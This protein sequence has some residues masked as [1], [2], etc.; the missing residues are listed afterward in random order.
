[1]NDRQKKLE[2][3]QEKLSRYDE[4]F[5]EERLQMDERE[6]IYRGRNR[7]DELV[8]GDVI[9][10]TPHVRNIAAEL[11]EAQVDPDIPQPKVTALRRQDE[12]L[13]VLI[14]DMLR[15]KLDSLPME[16]L[17]D[18][19]ERTVPIQGGGLFVLE[20]DSAGK[21]HD[22]TGR[23][24]V[25]VVHPKQLSP[26]PGV[27]GDMEEME[28]F[29]LKLPQTK[30][31][32]LRRYGVDVSEGTEEEPEIRGSG[33]VSPSDELVTQYVAYYRNED[34][35]IGLFSWVNDTVLEDLED[36]QSRVLCRC[37]SCG[38]VEPAGRLLPEAEEDDEDE[39]SEGAVCPV[40]GGT[41]RRRT[42]EFEELWLPVTRSDGTVIPGAD[43]VTGEPNLIPYYKPDI[44]PV[45]LQKSVSVY[46]RLLGESDV[47]KVRDQQ[48]TIN[49]LEKS[50][51]DQLLAAGTYISLPPD[52][53]IRMDTGVAKVI[54][55][56]NVTDKNYLG[57]Y[58]M[59]CD[60]DQPLAYL[61]YVY[62]EARNIIGIT[63]SY[64]GRRDTTATS[65]VAKE[66]AANQTA[67]RLQSKRVMKHACW[68]RLFE[69][70]FKFE[71]A[72]A[73]EKRPILGRDENGEPRDEEWNRFDFLE[74]DEAG[75]WVWNDR[76]LF[77]CDDAQALAADRS[78]MWQETRG[79]YSA[80]AFGDPN[81][82]Q[83]R[84]L[85]WTKMEQLH[86]PGAAQTRQSLMEEQR[87]Q[88]E[89]AAMQPQMTAPG[90]IP[91]VKG[92]G[93]P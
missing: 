36:C 28:D 76:F 63:D 5:S 91:V 44:Y 17:N 87:R 33:E 56:K 81:E 23:S 57:V 35:G 49:R 67:G 9:R 58:D 19:M 30:Q 75:N 41:L 83:T 92:G 69:G 45:F 47:D 12:H 52:P 32:I 25:S 86:Y 21:S 38:A 39:E 73:D 79:Y 22:G 42:E 53:S 15:S 88:Q 2:M 11:I 18:Q 93:M 71:L 77:S 48:N 6:E 24:V 43:P 85:F 82:M 3:W 8:D 68:A 54:R 60:V 62:Q 89:E 59:K 70:L 27:T 80:G 34:G 90:G 74:Q 7:I 10:S 61:D 84:I 66:F 78:A 20:W 64:Q 65:G 4:A 14:E 46:G 1:M 16:L 26:Q 55:L 50:I 51:I 37:E 72:Y 29:I 40:C 31:Y 13:A